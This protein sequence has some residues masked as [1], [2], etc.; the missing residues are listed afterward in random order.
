M[1]QDADYRTRFGGVAR[2]FGKAG[3]DRLRAISDR[4]LAEYLYQLHIQA[5]RNEAAERA[6]PAQS[7]SNGIGPR[8]LAAR[9]LAGELGPEA[10]ELATYLL[11]DDTGRERTD[12][13]SLGAFCRALQDL[14]RRQAAV[15]RGTRG[16]GG[17]IAGVSCGVRGPGLGSKRIPR[18]RSGLRTKPE[19]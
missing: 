4:K 11:L 17:L 3:L 5:E 7:T 14:R 13:V 15:E 2:L 18:S 9:A 16:G 8:R 10:R 6:K 19:G 12:G 1:T